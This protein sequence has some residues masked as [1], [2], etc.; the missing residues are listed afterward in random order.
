MAMGTKTDQATPM[1]KWRSITEAAV[2]FISFC[3]LSFSSRFVP[4]I[5]LLTVIS[6]ITF[7]LIW[8]KL[9]RSWA[10]IGF[11]R[12]NIRQ[13]LMWGAGAGM[14]TIVYIFLVFGGEQLFPPMLGLQLTIGIPIWV[15]VM[16]PFQEFLFRG[17]LQPRFQCATGKWIG[18]TITSACFTL[19]HFAPPFE[20]TPTSTL[21]ITSINGILSTFGLGMLFGYVF[22][23]TNN[24]V[25]P[26]LAH[27]L[28]GIGAVLVGAMTFIYYNP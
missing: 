9:T 5:F 15:L 28:A 8:A 18:L 20:G 7:P 23:R 11:T 26:W 25:A 4:A 13:A 21:P 6:G 27:T 10:S 16:S 19:W 12:T 2:A 24:I 1:T 17:W 14:V 22:Q 3:A